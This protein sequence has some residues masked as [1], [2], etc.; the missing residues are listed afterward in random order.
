MSEFFEVCVDKICRVNNNDY[1]YRYSVRKKNTLYISVIKNNVEYDLAI[2]DEKCCDQYDI[3]EININTNDLFGVNNLVLKNCCEIV[4]SVLDEIEYN[5]LLREIKRSISKTV[6]DLLDSLKNEDIN[7]E[8]INNII[9]G[10]INNYTMDKIK[11]TIFKPI[12][13]KLAR[14]VR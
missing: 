4:Y 11:Y 2:N 5:M 12:N 13:K 1:R 9:V 14:S 7:I 8:H 6:K 10:K 3:S